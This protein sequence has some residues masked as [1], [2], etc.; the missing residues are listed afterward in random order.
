MKILK[1][2][3]DFKFM[4]KRMFAFALS[5]L[6]I[7]AGAYV[8]FT[9]GFNLGIEFTGGTLIEIGFKDSIDVASVKDMLKEGG[10]ENFLVQKVGE[11]DESTFLIK[12]VADKEKMKRKDFSLAQAGEEIRKI[13]VKKFGDMK[14]DDGKKNINKVTENDLSA[15]LKSKGIKED[16]AFENARLIKKIPMILNFSDIDSFR[17]ENGNSILPNISALIKENFSV[18][19]PDINQMSKSELAFILNSFWK[20]SENADVENI[21]SEIGK[22]A[23]INNIVTTVSK[24]RI[25]TNFNKMETL[26]IKS[27]SETYGK[28]IKNLLNANSKV[29]DEVVTALFKDKI[30]PI[31]K[32]HTFIGN[33]KVLKEKAIGAQV[34]YDL[35]KKTVLATIWALIGMLVYVAFRF[36]FV[37]GVSA[38]VT[39]AHDI[40]ISLSA[41]LFFNVEM[42][43]S[44]VAALLT[45]VGYS[46]NDT[47]VIFDR[48]RDN[49]KPLKREGADVVLD[50]SINQ[51]LSRT[52]VTS[53]TTLITVLSLFFFGGDVIHAFS[54]TLIVGVIVGTY[55]S[56]FQSC[57]WLKIW[58]KYFLETKKK[59]K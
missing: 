36:K 59:K 53:G 16:I 6:I 50:K 24:L 26:L 49:I 48:V 13:F 30:T 23:I 25:V 37:F 41:I 1:K 40:L 43:L 22:K 20:N 8:F 28:R 4:K 44:V 38:L 42:S 7:L 33:I 29:V 39:L 17:D 45:I 54:F 18:R 27:F 2:E 52:I 55:S 46:L 57:A 12:T 35:Q 47:I 21:V 51:T 56:I 34:G 11:K 32:A 19:L 58:E 9:K 10:F 14:N 3:P 15:F 5:G 31:I